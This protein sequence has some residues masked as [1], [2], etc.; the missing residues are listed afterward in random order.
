MITNDLAAGAMSGAAA[1][2]P[3]TAFMEAA[4]HQL[5]FLQQAPLPPRQITDNLARSFGVRQELSETTREVATLTA[6]LGYGAACGA[7]Y[8]AV[9]PPPARGPSTGIAF[10]MGVWTGSYLALLPALGLLSPATRH[11]W[12]RN[13]L[14]LGAHVVWGGVLGACLAR[15]KN[16]EAAS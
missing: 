11:P 4:Y 15:R 2:V 6:H 12:R 16:D 3:M 1:T 10:A 13:A 14:M 7:L 8:T 5:P 9:T